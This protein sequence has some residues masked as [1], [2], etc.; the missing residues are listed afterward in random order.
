MY[1]FLAGERKHLPACHR[2]FVA[3]IVLRT[4][5]FCLI[6]FTCSSTPSV[7]AKTTVHCIRV[8]V[9]SKPFELHLPRLKKPTTFFSAR[10]FR[11]LAIVLLSFG[12]FVNRFLKQKP[13]NVIANWFLLKLLPPKRDAIFIYQTMCSLITQDRSRVNV[14]RKLLET[15]TL[16][17]K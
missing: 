3:I 7:L 13:G 6:F 2:N 9:A 8:V 1:Y 16:L 11:H 14:W 17:R 12:C 4:H 10:F 5:F 15:L